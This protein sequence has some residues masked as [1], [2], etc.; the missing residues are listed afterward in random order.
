MNDISKNSTAV[1]QGQSMAETNKLIAEDVDL[2]SML[3]DIMDRYQCKS[4]EKAMEQMKFQL[5]IY[6]LTSKDISLLS[7][8]GHFKEDSATPEHILKQ[9]E[10]KLKIDKLAVENSDDR[11]IALLSECEKNYI[12][13][14]VDLKKIEDSIKLY[15]FLYQHPALKTVAIKYDDRYSDFPDATLSFLE[16]YL[17]IEDKLTNS[18]II[19]DG[20]TYEF[21]K[22]EDNFLEFSR[23]ITTEMQQK[24]L[25]S[26]EE[27][28]QLTYPGSSIRSN[29]FFEELENGNIKFETKRDDKIRSD[30]DIVLTDSKDSD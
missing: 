8:E 16:K 24:I 11:I 12:N 5:K 3:Q 29:V 27:V 2:A 17:K 1:E 13:Y 9:M 4:L 28:A 15:E 14:V 23:I 6:E 21:V 30:L 19:I 26:K 22:F 10:A 7:I 25:A 20:F 18:I